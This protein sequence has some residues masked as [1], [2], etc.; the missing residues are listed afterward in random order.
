MKQWETIHF[1]E[2]EMTR[3]YLFVRQ[4]PFLNAFFKR[5]TLSDFL[6]FFLSLMEGADLW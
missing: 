6:E 2:F 1:L 3:R 4:V 5:K